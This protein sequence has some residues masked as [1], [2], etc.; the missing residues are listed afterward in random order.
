MTSKDRVL[1]QNMTFQQNHPAA[2]LDLMPQK[3]IRLIERIRWRYFVAVQR[4]KMARK[5]EMDFLINKFIE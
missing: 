2:L 1:P 3:V 4:R 5:N